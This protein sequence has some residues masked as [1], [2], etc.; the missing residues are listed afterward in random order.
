MRPFGCRIA[1]TVVSEASDKAASAAMGDGSEQTVG[2]V[3]DAVRGKKLREV[4]R[5]AQIG[6]L[7]LTTVA[8]AAGLALLWVTKTVVGIESDAV[9]LALLIVPV[10]VMLAVT[11]RIK[12]LRL[13]GVSADFNELKASI[14]DVGQREP[15]R[16]AYLGKLEQVIR[17]DGTQFALIYADVDGLR[18]LSRARY[19]NQ[20]KSGDRRREEELRTEIVDGLELALTDAFYGK[21]DDKAKFDVFRLV[22]PD[23]AMI[24]RSVDARQ[25]YEIADAGSERFRNARACTTTTAV[26][27]A[28]HLIGEVTPKQLDDEAAKLLR[29]KKA[30]R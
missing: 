25:V 2:V 23:I 22:D 24:V 13:F 26:L 19:L 20:P 6:A 29:E 12:T 21:G 9:Y 14:T 15:E 5:K 18:K 17:K 16:A 4:V 11:G 8:L 7:M 30:A 28:A 27:P 1:S 10:L 3:P